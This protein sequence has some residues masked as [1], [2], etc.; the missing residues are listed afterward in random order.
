MGCG[1]C[2]PRTQCPAEAVDFS[3]LATTLSPFPELLLVVVWHRESPAHTPSKEQKGVWVLAGQLTLTSHKGSAGAQY[4]FPAH[5]ADHPL[6]GRGRGFPHLS[7]R[8][9]CFLFVS[10]LLS[11]IYITAWPG[12]IHLSVSFLSPPMYFFNLSIVLS[13]VSGHGRLSI[14]SY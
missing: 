6:N 9:F 7:P 4:L 11:I 14:T 8:L 1:S 5:H 2:W 10:F 12:L 13:I 3:L